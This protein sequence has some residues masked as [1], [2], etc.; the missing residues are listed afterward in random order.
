MVITLMD[1]VIRSKALNG[2]GRMREVQRLN[3]DGLLRGDA[4]ASGLR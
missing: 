2:R 3:G 1:L 4:A